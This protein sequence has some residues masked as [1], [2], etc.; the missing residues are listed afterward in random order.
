M[1]KTITTVAVIII[2]ATAIAWSRSSRQLT[3]KTELPAVS[4]YEI[5]LQQGDKLPF[6]YWEE[7]F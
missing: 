1:R 5:M 6:Q 2:A 4:P 3:S 7:P